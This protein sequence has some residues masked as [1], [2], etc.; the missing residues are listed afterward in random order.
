MNDCVA[1]GMLKAANTWEFPE[2]KTLTHLPD[3]NTCHLV[4]VHYHL[5]EQ[6]IIKTSRDECH[7]P[8][9]TKEL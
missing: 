6:N 8:L 1:V 9:R 2:Q 5:S 3:G 4:T 7:Q